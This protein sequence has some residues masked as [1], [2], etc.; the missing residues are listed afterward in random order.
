MIKTT[1][2]KRGDGDVNLFIE[3]F[4]ETFEGQKA[5]VQVF[6]T[7][8]WVHPTYGD[9]EITKEDLTKAV[10]N[11][12]NTDRALVVDY[13]HG[14]DVGV[15]PED[16]KA[17]GWIRE[18]EIKELADGEAELWAL[19]DATD[20]AYEYIK[21]GEYRL[22][23]PTWNP[24]FENKE[25]GKPQGMTLLRGALTNSPFIDGMHPAVAM[26][27]RAAKVMKEGIKL[28]GTNIVVKI[29][30]PITNGEPKNTEHEAEAIK[31]A[32]DPGPA[33][34]EEPNPGEPEPKP[35]ASVFVLCSA[36][37]EMLLTRTE[38]TK[39]ALTKQ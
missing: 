23:S 16:R 28:R 9:L 24:N 15:T 6:R 19:F 35:S 31:D 18:L 38:R 21:N 11:F 17:A 36:R 14:T 32:K 5:R 26:N 27:E 13:D 33:P 7:G 12:M 39:A 4:P 30:N 8:S 37:E 25:S 34:P 2:G 1:E 3:A 10:D 22:F 20:K 29:E